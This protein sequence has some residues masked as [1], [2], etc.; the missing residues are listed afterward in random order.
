M[1]TITITL[2]V[3]DDL[4]PFTRSHVATLIGN[5]SNRNVIIEVK[6]GELADT[7]IEAI[8]GEKHEGKEWI[9][10]VNSAKK[11]GFSSMKSPEDFMD[12]KNL[13]LQ[14]AQDIIRKHLDV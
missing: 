2:Q 6:E 10:M 13:G 5:E 1:K 12:G 8:E 4:K 14:T 9:E 3:A 7:L 11:I